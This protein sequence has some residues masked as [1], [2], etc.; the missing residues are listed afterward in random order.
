[1]SEIWLEQEVED[2][3]IILCADHIGLLASWL[4][5][6]EKSSPKG[7]RLFWVGNS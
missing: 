7:Y 2:P 1:M 3:G 5:K 4:S 6:E